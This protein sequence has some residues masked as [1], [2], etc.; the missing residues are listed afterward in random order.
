VEVG[1]FLVPSLMMLAVSA[2]N[3]NLSCCSWMFL[4]SS[5]KAFLSS[6]A[7][8][9]SSCA[10]FICLSSSS[11]LCSA[12]SSFASSSFA[13]SSSFFSFSF[14]AVPDSDD[15]WLMML[16]S[17]PN[18]PVCSW[19]WFWNPTTWSWAAS[20]WEGVAVDEWPAS[21]WW[22]GSVRQRGAT[23]YGG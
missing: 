20:C 22:D 8:F 4:F 2:I 5:I 23:I 16:G 10:C 11:A 15:N 17:D 6:C 7:W 21:L 14:S 3:L 9:L 18:P 19:T 13:S 12:S 1:C